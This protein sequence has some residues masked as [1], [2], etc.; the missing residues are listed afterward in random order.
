MLTREKDKLEKALGGI[1]DMGGVPDL[2]FVIDTNKEQ[3]AIKE[4]QRLGIPVAAIVDTNCNPDGISYIVPAN[5]DA[6]RAIALYCDLIAR[7]A[8]EGIGRG[9]GALGIDAGA[10][11]EPTA[12]ELPANDDVAAS[13]ASDAI[14]PADVA[15]LAESTEHFEQLAAPRGAPDDL[16]KLS[17]VGP[18][19]VQKLNDAGVWHYWQI[20]AMQPEDVSKLDADLKLNG[21]I[22]RDG[23]IEQSRAFVDAAAA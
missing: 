5:D 8:I 13:V 12:E 9:Q 7:A 3:L 15:A 19:L 20:A 2:L 14:A 22:A 23:W 1:K 4:A 21:R 11:E 10:S 16:T 18:Q 17:G 6:G